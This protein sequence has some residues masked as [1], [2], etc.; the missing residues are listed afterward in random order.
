MD[1]KDSKTLMDLTENEK[2][3]LMEVG[4]IMF[5]KH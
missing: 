5:V 2:N 4:L 3:I 1:K